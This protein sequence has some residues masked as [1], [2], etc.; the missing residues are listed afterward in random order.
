MTDI[1]DLLFVNNVKEIKM[2]TKKMKKKDVNTEEKIE[3]KETKN[4]ELKPG[5]GLDI[6]TGFLVGSSFNEKNKVNFTPLRNAFFSI[7]KDMFHK[8]M[9]NKNSMKW[10]EM[11]NDIFVIGEDALT[12]A[13]IKNT[14]AR[15]PLSSGIINSKERDAAP[16]LKEMF[17]YCVIPNKKTDNEVCVF[18]V[19]GPKINDLDFDVDFHSMSLESLISSFGL[20][21]EPLN[22]GYAVI[23]SEIGDAKDVTGLGISFGAGLVNV[24]FAYKSMKLF[25]FSID[26]SGDFID[27]KAAEAVNIGES[28]I[29]HI[30]ENELDLDITEDKMTPEQR[31]L[32]FAYRYVIRNVWK[33]ILRAFTDNNDIKILEPIPVIV[34]GGTSLPS[35]FINMFEN[36]MIKLPFEI[37]EIKTAKNRLGA[38]SQGCLIWANYISNNK[39]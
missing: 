9:F 29:S 39:N 17:K 2:N 34:S 5:I 12:L 3:K 31:A 33:E 8:T 35:G 7:D 26:K 25:E 28:M 32:S 36:E 30:K 22:E 4:I 18:S 15:R 38:V 27:K 11:N 14:H 37:T 19:P 10:V 21:S 24:C 20:Q 1:D 16:V 23:L 13:K 6:G